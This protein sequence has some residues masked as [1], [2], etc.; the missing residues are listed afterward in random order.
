MITKI[1][2]ES[3]VRELKQEAE[4]QIDPYQFAGSVMDLLKEYEG[5]I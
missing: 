2:V 4:E 3:F 5:E 1:D